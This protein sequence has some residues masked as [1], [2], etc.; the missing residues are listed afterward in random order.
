[1]YIKSLGSLLDEKMLLLKKIPEVKKKVKQ[2]KNQANQSKA[3]QSKA[4]QKQSV[5]YVIEWLFTGK[6]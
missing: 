1:M 6:K 2:T 3:K 4:K 5:H